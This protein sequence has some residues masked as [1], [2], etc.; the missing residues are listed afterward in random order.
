MKILFISHSYPPTIGGVETHNAELYTHLAK[1]SDVKLLANRKRWLIPFF[2]LSASVYAVM[3]AKKYDV[4]VL[5]SCILGNVGWLVK[6]ITGKPVIAVAHGLDLTFPNLFYQKLWVNI[7]LKKIDKFIAVGNETV[8]IAKEKGF[9]ENKIVFIPNGIDMEKLAGNYT[10]ADLEKI[11]GESTENKKIILTSGRLVKRKGVAWFLK[12]I[13]PQLPENVIYIIAGD[14]PDKKNIWQTIETNNLQKRTRVLGRISE[15]AKK[16]LLHTCDLFVQP[17]IKVPGDMEGFGI[18]VL[19]AAFCKIPAIVSDLEG[20]KD[21]IQDGQN[22]FLVASENMEAWTEK[23]KQLLSDDN[24]RQEFGN[25]AQQYVAQ[26][27]SW[28]I[29]AEKYLA[30]IK[31]VIAKSKS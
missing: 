10:R 5:G 12:N 14:G 20:L 18:S 21:A 24:S 17:N 25:R 29:I 26:N 19:E 15:E 7:F 22:G 2:L 23:I 13:L 28:E 31:A 6:K 30:E 16:V 3:T 8:R 4:I 27:F 9:P 1:Q 11:L